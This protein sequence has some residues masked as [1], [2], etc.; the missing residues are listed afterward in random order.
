MT[1]EELQGD[2]NSF[3]RNLQVTILNATKIIS[4]LNVGFF[5]KKTF[6]G[7]RQNKVII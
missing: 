2:K 1:K 5:F 4:S 7:V 6:V 3:I